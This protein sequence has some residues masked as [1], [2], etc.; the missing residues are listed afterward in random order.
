MQGLISNAE[1]AAVIAVIIS[2][3]VEWF[4][5]LATW[6]DQFSSAQKQGIMAAMVMVVSIAAVFVQCQRGGECPTDWLD[7]LVQAFLAFIAAAAANQGVHM[8]TKKRTAA[9]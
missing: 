6:Y 3:L 8:L 7:F 2:L 5:G 4:P 9:A 1:I